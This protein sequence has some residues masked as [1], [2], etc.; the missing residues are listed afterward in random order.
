MSRTFVGRRNGFTIIEM[1]IVFAVISI[2][3]AFA[4][5]R[6]R[7]V[8]TRSNLRAARDQIAIGLASAR[9]SAVQKGQLSTFVMNGNVMRVALGGNGTGM[10]V[11][12]RRDLYDLY[13]AT[14]EVV[15]GGVS[16]P[17]DSLLTYD[18]RGFVAAGTGDHRYRV[19]V[20]GFKDSVCVSKL[21][22]TLKNG[23]L[24]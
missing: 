14:V 2:M 19:T 5:P 1:L 23:C 16:T 17:S 15:T 21:G 13:G 4:V 24:P 20:G 11:L 22:L 8:K 10:R 6:A 12:G 3:V 7:A 9:A 18:S